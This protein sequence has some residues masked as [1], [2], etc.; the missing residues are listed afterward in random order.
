MKLNDYIEYYEN[1]LDKLEKHK[2][3]LLEVEKSVRYTD[4]KIEFTYDL[5]TI[6]RSCYNSEKLREDSSEYKNLL[7]TIQHHLNNIAKQ[8][9]EEAVKEEKEKLINR[10][11]EIVEE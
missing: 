5:L 1:E 11:K 3:E 4:T 7:F 2:I 6:L 8:E 9:D 10:L